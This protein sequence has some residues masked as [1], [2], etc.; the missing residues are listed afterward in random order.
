MAAPIAY[1]QEEATNNSVRSTT[2]SPWGQPPSQLLRS[3]DIEQDQTNADTQ[4][5]MAAISTIRRIPEHAQ[6]GYDTPALRGGEVFL[7]APPPCVH[8]WDPYVP[9]QYVR[10]PHWY[11]FL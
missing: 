6:H 1:N 3:Y 9:V 8:F 2:M 7:D 4:R 11:I 5:I 10:P